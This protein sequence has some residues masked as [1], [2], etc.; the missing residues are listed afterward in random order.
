M[1][2]GKFLV[3]TALMMAAAS[4]GHAVPGVGDKVTDT[5]FTTAY[6][7]TLSLADLRGEVV[8]LTYWMSDCEPCKEQLQTLDYYYRQRKDVGL[9]VLA[10]APEDLSERQLKYEFR[11]KAIHPLASVSGSFGPKDTFPTTYIIDR[12]GQVQYAK[13]GAIG[14]EQLNELLV[15]LLKQPQP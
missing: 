13:S 4:A 8:I 7:Q 6:G 1:A 15:P 10:F 5:R 9:R 11:D 12:Y 14:I 2:V 3:T